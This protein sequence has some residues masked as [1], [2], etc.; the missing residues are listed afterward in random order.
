MN[1]VFASVVA[2]YLYA[3]PALLIVLGL[4]ALRRDR[5]AAWVPI[6]VGL[7]F[8][9]IHRLAALGAA[10]SGTET[11]LPPGLIPLWP[12]AVIAPRHPYVQTRD[13]AS[14]GRHATPR[15]ETAP[16]G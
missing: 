10:V 11:A 1:A 16:G 3:L 5:L 4:T 13:R 7:G 8:V 12:A 6:A 2:A 14:P 9:L 15:G